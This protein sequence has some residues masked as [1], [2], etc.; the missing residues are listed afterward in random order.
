[1]R[2]SVEPDERLGVPRSEDG[3]VTPRSRESIASA[4]ASF[5]RAAVPLEGRRPAAVAVAI[6]DDGDEHGLLLTRRSATMRVNPGQW[7]LPGGRADA[8]ETAVAAALREMEEELGLGCAEEDVLGLLDDY[9]TRSGYV[10]TPVVVWCGRIAPPVPNAAE[11]ASVHVVRFSALD[12]E[13]RFVTIPE[14][15]AP[16]IQLPLVGDYVHAP[17]AALLHQF[18]EVALHGRP[19]RV[20]HYEQ[21]VFAWR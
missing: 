18:R 17:T 10:I 12:V 4:L 1:M 19:T 3:G 9:A 21:P 2:T 20:A 15:E 16:V 11:V 13:P 14:S 6:V 5:E 7:A 8:G